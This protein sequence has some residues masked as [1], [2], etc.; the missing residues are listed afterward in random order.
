MSITLPKRP[1]ALEIN[2]PIGT[3]YAYQSAALRARDLEVAKCVLEA[4]LEE[5]AKVLKKAAEGS[6]WEQEKAV[7]LYY[8]NRIKRI[9]N[10]KVSHG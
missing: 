2:S 6:A 3:L 1:P 9:R 10:L 5:A 8:S 7:L 4:A